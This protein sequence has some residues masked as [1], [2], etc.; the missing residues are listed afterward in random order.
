MS[1]KGSWKGECFTPGCASA[2][3]HIATAEGPRVEVPQERYRCARCCDLVGLA[4]PPRPED[5]LPSRPGWD[6]WCAELDAIFA[7]PLTALEKAAAG[8][9]P[10]SVYIITGSDLEMIANVFRQRTPETMRLEFRRDGVA[11]KFDAA[12]WTPTIG[13]VSPRE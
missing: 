1:I 12:M 13:S 8:A 9:A 4:V 11:V 3:R 2:A 10:N 5:V 7:L 6:E